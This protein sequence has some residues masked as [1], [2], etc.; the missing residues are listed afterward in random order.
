VLP[1]RTK[2]VLSHARAW[3]ALLW[4]GIAALACSSGEGSSASASVTASAAVSSTAGAATADSPF[5]APDSIAD[6]VN[7]VPSDASVVASLPSPDAFNANIPAD[8]LK[9]A[10]DGL[11]G[12]LA[13]KLGMPA[14]TISKLLGSYEGAVVFVLGGAKDPKGAA[15]IRVKDATIIKPA[16]E[17]AKFENKGNG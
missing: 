17:E 15:A 11:S 13:P 2:I 16:L 10:L 12:M 6:L 7:L 1:M 8:T 5:V 9:Q 4:L 14:A 3:A